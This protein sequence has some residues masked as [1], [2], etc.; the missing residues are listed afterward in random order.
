MKS[1]IAANW[2][3]NMDIKEAASFIKKFKT[4]IKNNKVEVVICPS[5]VSLNELS[6]LVR[7]TQI[8][9]GAQNM[10]FEKEGAFTGE[11]SALM[12]KDI[13]DYVIL[14]HSDRRQFFKVM[15]Y[16]FY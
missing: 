5:F 9:I 16:F 14:G 15:I 8:K 7:N 12:L 6:K 10:Y 4:L 11:V 13:C 1:L 3:M 2:K